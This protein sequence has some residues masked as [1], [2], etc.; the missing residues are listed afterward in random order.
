MTP[1]EPVS[2]IEML[3]QVRGTVD[4][5]PASDRQVF[6]EARLEIISVVSRHGDAGRAALGLALMEFLN[7]DTGTTITL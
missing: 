6:D 3:S 7:A 4:A 5:M 2:L 1:D